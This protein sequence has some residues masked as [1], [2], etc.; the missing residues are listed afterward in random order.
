MKFSTREDVEVPVAN[1]FEAL[2]DFD[3][4]ERRAMR[5]GADVTRT[6]GLDEPGVGMAWEVSFK[7]RGRQRTLTPTLTKYDA[8][9]TLEIVSKAGGLDI[10]LGVDLLEMSPNRTR[11]TVGVELTPNTL[12]ARLLVQSLKLAKANLTKRFK[13]SLAE[14]A[15]GIER[16]HRGV[17]VG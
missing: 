4:F 17:V 2:S 3:N 5:R 10:V 15:E 16:D 14:Y 6:D 13:A 9:T 1:V 11:M 12:S 7:Y 8:P